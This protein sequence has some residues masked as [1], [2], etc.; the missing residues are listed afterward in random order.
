M[1]AGT[2]IIIV[3]LIAA[4]CVGGG[5]GTSQTT[6][7]GATP[8]VDPPMVDST[9]EVEPTI[10][11]TTSGDQSGNRVTDGTGG[12]GSEPVTLEVAS[13][14]WLVGLPGVG[15][16][17]VWVVADDEGVVSAFSEV[18]GEVSELVTVGRL[19]PGQPPVVMSDGSRIALL[20]GGLDSSPLTAPARVDGVTISMTIEGTVTLAGDLVSTLDALA[21]DDSRIV[22][23]SLGRA[24]VLSVPTAEYGHGVLGDRIESLT[25]TVFDPVSGVILG[26]ATAPEGTV[27]EA[28]SPMWGDVDS[29]G[30]DELVVTAS[31]SRAG[32]RLV[33]YEA[34]GTVVAM[35]PP[36]GNGNRWRNLLAIAPTAPEGSVEVVEV[37]TPHIGGILQWF[38]LEG[39]DL[40]LQ[41]GESP[42]STHRLGSRNLDQ[43]VVVDVDGDGRLDT[44]VPTQDQEGLVAW[45]RSGDSAEPVMEL[46]LGSR[47]ATNI[48]TAPRSDGSVAVAVGLDDGRLL[49]WP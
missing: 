36:V 43:G 4:A 14:V 32:A 29:D 48:A 16:S 49:L 20:D 7:T 11:R 34:D 45:A 37:Q 13:P 12:M 47:L 40:V 26:T 8:T 41:A 2:G 5:A 39:E 46:D 27:F 35:S 3:G 31:D 42:F 9:G 38:S 10:V 30:T 23:D 6:T 1:R 44:L 17:T 25:V 18:D 22:V 24:A 19:A 33:V 21:L 15:A 28:L